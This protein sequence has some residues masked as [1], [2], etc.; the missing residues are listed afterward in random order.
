MGFPRDFLSYNNFE[1]AFNRV[2]RGANKDYKAFYK[3]LCPS[4]NLAVRENLLD[5]ID[6]LKRGTFEPNKP[7][8]IFQPKKSGVLR[9]LTLLSLRDLIV[10]QAIVNRVAVAFETE[11]QA[12]ALK[13][14]FGAIFAG[15]SSDF[16]FRSWKASYR[17]YNR[18]IK[19]AFQNGK[20]FIADFDLVSFYELIEHGLL[21]EQLRHRIKNDTLIELL[22]TCLEG[23][24]LKKA[25]AAVGHR[26]PQGPEPS[27]FLA[28]CFL[29]YFDSADYRGVTYLRYIDDIR[30]MGKDEIPIRRALLRLDLHSKELGLVPQA[31]K[32]A[33][34]RVS[35]LDE[36]LKTIPSPL[37]EFEDD[38]HGQHGT[39][40]SLIKVFRQSL[41]KSSKVWIVERRNKVQILI[42]SPERTEG[43]ASPD[44]SP[45]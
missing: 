22:M 29:F 17:K 14:S 30:L 28:E 26:V 8:L 27:A 36:V 6:D 13:K 10:F 44:S 9:P 34:R 18:A 31:E 37:A 45:P 5:V 24:T 41:K 35:D 38:P 21:A 20:D 15:P 32:I 16:F 7:T 23:W 1:L 40:A 39:Q 43:C 33:C 25:G 4:Y 3:H 2:V 11:Q 19:K 42:E 12:Y